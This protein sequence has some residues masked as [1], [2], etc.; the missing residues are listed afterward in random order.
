VR[1]LVVRYARRLVPDGLAVGTAGNLS[2][3]AGADV[4][5]ITPSALEYDTLTP[6]LV[7]LVRVDGTVVEGEPS[8]ELPMHL[9]AYE[10]AGTAA[11]VHTHSAF[12]TALGTVAEELPAIHYL[13]ADLGGPVPVVPYATPGSAELAQLVASALAGRSAVLLRNHG[14]LTVGDSLPHAY[15]RAL[16]LE[17]LAALYYR[18]RALGD[19]AL[20]EQRELDRLADLLK[21]Y[22][23]R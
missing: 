2:A 7:S 20:L 3:R 18:A 13:V 1:E 11:V 21:G 19:P 22:G 5:A 12:A 4:V 8:T 9:A 14:A 23:R 15:A 10:E 17:W 16:L 6:D